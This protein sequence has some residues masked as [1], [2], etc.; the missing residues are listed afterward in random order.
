MLVTASSPESSQQEKQNVKRVTWP[1]STSCPSVPSLDHSKTSCMAYVKH[2][3]ILRHGAQLCHSSIHVAPTRPDVLA[4][5][6]LVQHHLGQWL[7]ADY[8]TGWAQSPC[9][10]QSRLKRL[11]LFI[12]TI[13]A[14][15][16]IWPSSVISN[17]FQQNT[18]NDCLNY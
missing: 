1:P 7:H 12:Q 15:P 10:R 5:V 8:S 13:L 2:H 6:G 18:W 16:I 11:T 9:P 4:G 3:V 14:Y 17:F